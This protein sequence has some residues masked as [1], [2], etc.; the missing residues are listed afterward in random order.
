MALIIRSCGSV[1]AVLRNI[2]KNA[3]DWFDLVPGSSKSDLAHFI[4]NW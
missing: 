3:T 1:K 2:K 4:C